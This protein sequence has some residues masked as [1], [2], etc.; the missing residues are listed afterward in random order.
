MT[1]RQEIHRLAEIAKYVRRITSNNVIS[2]PLTA[3]L[4]NLG[5]VVKLPKQLGTVDAIPPSSLPFY[6]SD[7]IAF[8]LPN[9]DFT[10]SGHT[11]CLLE[12]AV[13]KETQLT[14]GE[15]FGMV[16]LRKPALN[17]AALLGTGAEIVIGLSANSDSMSSITLAFPGDV[18]QW[19]F[20]KGRYATVD[21]E[22][23]L[24]SMNVTVKRLID[25]V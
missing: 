7:V 17:K 22:F 8:D 14:L 13:T 23:I 11:T 21:A 19:H 20:F 12:I 15:D 10:Y 18:F 6:T 2:V 5:N 25:Y 16:L 3:S 9:P 1:P 4:E 24:H